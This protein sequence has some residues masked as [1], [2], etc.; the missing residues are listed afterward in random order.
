MLYKWFLLQISIVTQRGRDR[1]P[2]KRNSQ[3]L[4]WLYGLRQFAPPGVT[5]Q[6]GTETL[7]NGN[8]KIQKEW[9]ELCYGKAETLEDAEEAARW[10]RYNL[11]R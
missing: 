4:G 1:Y 7:R 5:A 11:V 3:A 9:K 8:R 6:E 2:I 10:W